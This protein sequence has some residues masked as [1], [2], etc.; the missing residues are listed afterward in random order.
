[1]NLYNVLNNPSLFKGSK[2][3]FIFTKAAGSGVVVFI[4]PEPLPSHSPA[5][6][7]QTIEDW[8]QD[9]VTSSPIQIT[10]MQ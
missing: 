4:V 5:L 3:D 2:Q 9:T 1:M 10:N 7:L 6:L 8:T